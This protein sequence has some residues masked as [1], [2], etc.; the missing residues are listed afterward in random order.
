VVISA[1]KNS[2]VVTITPVN[3]A[4]PEPTETV[5]LSILDTAFYEVGTPGSALVSIADDDG[6]VPDKRED[7]KDVCK[8][9]GWKDFGVFKNQGDCV[10]Y[11]ATGGKNP[12]ALGPAP[13]AIKSLVPTA[14][15]NGHP[16]NGKAKG[17]AK[18]K[19]R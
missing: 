4:T 8:N 7:P 11:I 1:G 17:K 15:G 14:D 16:A 6:Y 18:G 3:D 12:P 2:Q 9:G 19:N 10:S 5:V 13:T